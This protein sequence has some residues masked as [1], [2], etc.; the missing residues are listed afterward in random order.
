MSPDSQYLIERIQIP[1]CSIIVDFIGSIC[2]VH[3]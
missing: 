2:S 1:E 3:V